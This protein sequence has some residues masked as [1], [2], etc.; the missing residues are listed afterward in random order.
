[1]DG[2][3][4]TRAI[5]NWEQAQHAPRTNIVAL[6]ASALSEDAD[7]AREAGCDAHVTKPVKKTTLFEVI[8]QYTACA[9]S[10]DPA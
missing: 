10:A 3:A 8:R 5:R 4:A 2:Y 9:T 1:M 6:T 7:W